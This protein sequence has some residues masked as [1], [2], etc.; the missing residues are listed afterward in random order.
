MTQNTNR[1]GFDYQLPPTLIY[2]L[3]HG[4]TWEKRC[5]PCGRTVV[6]DL[7]RVLEHHDIHDEID[8]S[9]WRCGECGRKLEGHTGLVIAA[10][11]HIG[12]WPQEKIL[13]M[14]ARESVPGF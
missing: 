2:N 13:V 9:R 11:R 10:V 12:R 1:Q 14:P 4:Q 8:S 7:L 5:P 3:V 6:I